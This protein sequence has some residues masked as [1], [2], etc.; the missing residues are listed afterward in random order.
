MSSSGRGRPSKAAVSTNF[1]SRSV[2]PNHLNVYRFGD[3]DGATPTLCY[4]RD[5]VIPETS[6][7]GNPPRH[8]A[9]MRLCVRPREEL[10]EPK[11]DNQ[12]GKTF[13]RSSDDSWVSFTETCGLRGWLCI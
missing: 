10:P 7:E 2:D 1:F 3:D 4:V 13:A 12:L 9:N 6:L 11:S 8:E 5:T